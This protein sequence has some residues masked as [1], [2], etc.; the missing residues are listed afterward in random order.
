MGRVVRGRCS[1]IAGSGGSILLLR[2]AQGPSEME[3]EM[4]METEKS[5]RRVGSGQVKVNFRGKD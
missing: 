1:G 5:E 3:M 2:H 4:E